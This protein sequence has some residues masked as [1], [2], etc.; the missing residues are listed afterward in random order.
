VAGG[1]LKRPRE[2]ASLDVNQGTNSLV[3]SV[4]GKYPQTVVLKRSG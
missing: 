3:H 4:D 1:L 2:A